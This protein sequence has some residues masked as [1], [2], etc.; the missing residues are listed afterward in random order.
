M[1]HPAIARHHQLQQDLKTK[2]PSG[3]EL[4]QRPRFP[5]ET[6]NDNARAYIDLHLLGGKCG[7]AHD[8][9]LSA[10]EG[11]VKAIEENIEFGWP[12]VVN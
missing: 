6:G 12:V 10:L 9:R 8:R 7:P 11:I 3:T 5:E 4:Q 1:L 2:E